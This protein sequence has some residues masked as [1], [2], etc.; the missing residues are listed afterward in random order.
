V[1]GVLNSGDSD[2]VVV[3]NGRLTVVDVEL[4]VVTERYTVIEAH[5]F[6]EIRFSLDRSNAQI[7]AMER[8]QNLVKG[9]FQERFQVTLT[10]GSGR[11]LAKEA[12]LPQ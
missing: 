7:N 4:P 3:R 6:E 11:V 8:W 9:G 12:R 10:E 1:I 5:S 2:G